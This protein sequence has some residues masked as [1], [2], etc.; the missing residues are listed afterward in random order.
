MKKISPYFISFLISFTI[1]I[2]FPFLLQ[3]QTLPDPTGDPDAPID[4]GLT[5]LIAAGI[6]YGVKK[7]RDN[8]KKKNANLI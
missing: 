7:N 1:L 5:F 4:G 2:I 6:G 3:A 8:R